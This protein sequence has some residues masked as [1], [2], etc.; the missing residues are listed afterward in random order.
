M[1]QDKEPGKTIDFSHISPYDV[2]DFD[3]INKKTNVMDMSPGMGSGYGSG[4]PGMMQQQ[5]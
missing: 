3:Q 2:D 5:F 4:N 1:S